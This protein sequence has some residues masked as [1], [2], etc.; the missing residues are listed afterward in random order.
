M[1]CHDVAPEPLGA[2]PDETEPKI[3]LVGR[4]NVGKS[5]LFNL[6]SG[7]RQKTMNVPRTTVSV[8]MGSWRLTP[9]VRAR[10][11]DL[12]G[13]YSLI[14]QSPDEEVTARAVG[15]LAVSAGQYDRVIVV[16]DATALASSLYLCAQVLQTS[17]PVVAALTMNDRA[18]EQRVDAEQLSWA[19]GVPVVEM[20]PRNGHG[21]TQLTEAVTASLSGTHERSFEVIELPALSIHHRLA[22]TPDEDLQRAE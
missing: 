2:I 15:D 20:N 1:S 19:I 18:G 22:A 17:V 6:L 21:A 5:T 14:P 9:T 16:L 12:P 4:P 3:L 7:A 10:V 11:T 13:T 8:E